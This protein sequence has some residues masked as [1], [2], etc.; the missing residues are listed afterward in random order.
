MIGWLAFV[1]GALLLSSNA[2][3]IPGTPGQLIVNSEPAADFQPPGEQATSDAPTALQ[4][5]DGEPAATPAL[6]DLVSLPEDTI[7]RQQDFSIQFGRRLA[8]DS[9]ILGKTDGIRVDYRLNSGLTLRGVAGYPVISSKDDFNTARQV[10]GFSADSG[11]FAR[12]WNLNAYLVDEQDNAQLDDRAIGGTLRY[13]RPK[14]SLLVSLDYDANQDTLNAITASGA[15]KLPGRIT[16]SATF[17]IHNRAIHKRRKKHLQHSM[18]ATDGW[19]WILP[20]DRI[21][22]YTS[23]QRQEVTTHGLSLSHAFSQR[24]KLSG[25]VAMLDISNN[26][27][28]GN[29]TPSEALPNEYFYHLKLTGKD[30]LISGNS[31]KLDIRHRVTGSSRISTASIDT[32][33]VINRLWNIS[34]RLRTEL[35]DNNTD[36]PA[37]W[38]ASPTVKM[39]YRWKKAYGFQIEAGGKWSSQ[40][41]SAEDTSHS[42]YLLSLGYQANF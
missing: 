15:W 24:F 30:L 40:A 17:D 14:R 19:N 34:P 6:P 23:T 42:T 33:Y 1:P 28:P 11:T 27:L 16:L 41:V 10:F 29:A 22:H 4:L 25:D 3:A 38:V 26:S 18:A 35:R 7:D 32:R 5:I 9:G 36:K 37:E 21:R 2:G 39:E 12:V 8:V 31:N 13:Q 20:D